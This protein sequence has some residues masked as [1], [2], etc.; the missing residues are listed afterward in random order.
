MMAERYGSLLSTNLLGRSGQ[1]FLQGT[2]GHHSQPNLV[3]ISCRFEQNLFDNCISPICSILTAIVAICVLS[4]WCLS[5][6]LRFRPKWMRSF[7]EE[8]NEREE[9]LQ[10]DEKRHYTWL[11]KALLIVVSLG[12]TLQIVTTL[13]PVANV[14][15]L[16]PV[17]S[18]V[19]IHP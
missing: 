8:S 15:A 19:T 14:I 18:W 6:L 2:D 7:I 10:T 9:E 16:L 11:F 13:Y 3:P 12:L 4:T 5:P 1:V 17:L